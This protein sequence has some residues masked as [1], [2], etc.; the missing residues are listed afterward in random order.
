MHIKNLRRRASTGGGFGYPQ[1][2]EPGEAHKT[3][4]PHKTPVARRQKRAYTTL[5]ETF[6][7]MLPRVALL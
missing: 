1:G 4:Q 2:G 7:S 5:A 6:T 3:V